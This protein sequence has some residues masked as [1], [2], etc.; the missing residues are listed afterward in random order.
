MMNIYY[1]KIVCNKIQTKNW[2]KIASYPDEAK[3]KN[4]CAVGNGRSGTIT[5]WKSICIKEK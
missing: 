1:G 5:Y 3:T 2:K 4:L